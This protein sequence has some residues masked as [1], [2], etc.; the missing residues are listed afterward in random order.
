PACGRPSR[1]PASPAG[2]PGRASGGTVM[3]DEPRS[4]GG[5][6]EPRPPESD[7]TK[8]PFLPEVLDRTVIAI[9]LFREIERVGESEP[10]DLIL[11]VNF[12]YPGGRAGAKKRVEDLI[13]QLLASPGAR[14][15]GLYAAKNRES[16]QYLFANLE[17]R[18][19]RELVRLDQTSVEPPPRAI[20]KVW[21]DFDVLGFINQS[22]S[23]VKAD[24]ARNAFGALGRDIVWAV[25]DSG[26]DK[27]HPHFKRYANLD[28]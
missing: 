14:G 1:E 25:V 8:K 28:L 18:L 20:Y 16:E 13:K 9:P 19:I 7:P 6:G 12:S 17:G 5:A 26:I 4:P 27:D 24:A 23:T 2:P 11:D 22:I 21:P 10:L 15:K 3:T